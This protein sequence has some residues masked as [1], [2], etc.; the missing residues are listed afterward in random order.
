MSEGWVTENPW[1]YLLLIGWDSN[2][3]YPQW[4]TNEKLK[5]VMSLVEIDVNS[6]KMFHVKYDGKIQCSGIEVGANPI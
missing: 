5:D 4:K 1:Q 2:D 3:A 6:V